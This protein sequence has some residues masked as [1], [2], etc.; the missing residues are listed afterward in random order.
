VYGPERHSRDHGPALPLRRLT[1]VMTGVIPPCIDPCCLIFPGGCAAHAGDNKLMFIVQP[2]LC[3]LLHVFFLQN[4]FP[5]RCHQPVKPVNWARCM[6]KVGRNGAFFF[7]CSV[8]FCLR[9]WFPAPCPNV[10]WPC[11][12]TL[13]LCCLGICFLSSR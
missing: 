12:L 13:S 2:V 6:R 1:R 7:I 5:P 10:I 11:P 9:R 4:L 3:A 8:F